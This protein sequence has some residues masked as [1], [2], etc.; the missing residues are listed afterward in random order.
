MQ[1]QALAAREEKGLTNEALAS[2]T[3]CSVGAIARALNAQPAKATPTL[4]AIFKYLCDAP[5]VPGDLQ[6]E[7][8]R[9]AQRTPDTAALLATL[10][11][12]V[13]RVLRRA[14]AG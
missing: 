4:E 12:E 5:A 1:A 11:E 8:R 10:F 13:A 3:G 9:L 2:A 6:A 14:A 7:I